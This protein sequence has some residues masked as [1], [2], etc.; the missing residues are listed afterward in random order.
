MRMRNQDDIDV[1][2]QTYYGEVFDEHVR[3]TTRSAQG[4]WSS[5]ARRRSSVS[6]CRSVA[7]L[8]SAVV[9]ASTHEH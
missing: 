1:R 7:S 5:S 3:L 2:I 8:T 4:P 9:Q 6:M